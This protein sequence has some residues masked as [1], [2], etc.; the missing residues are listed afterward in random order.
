MIRLAPREYQLLRLRA[1]GLTRRAAAAEMGLAYT[2]A[3]QYSAS[4]NRKL[5]VQSVIDAFRVAGWLHVPR[6]RAGDNDRRDLATRL[7]PTPRSDTGPHP[8]P[9][10][11]SA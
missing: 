1:L 6:D 3:M 10:K 9:M 5:G 7:R 4:T 11:E 8:V 2:T